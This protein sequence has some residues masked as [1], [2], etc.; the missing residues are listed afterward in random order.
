[1]STAPIPWWTATWERARERHPGLARCVQPVL[2]VWTEL[3]RIELVDRSLAL[4][5][6]ALLALIPLLMVL[7]VAAGHIGADGLAQVRDVMGVPEDELG[8]LVTQVERTTPDTTTL[9]VVVAL[10][11]ATSFS[12][13]LARMYAQVWQLERYRGLRAIRGSVVWLVGW[14]L[15]LQ[16]TA[17][18]I[19]WS[20]PVPISSLLIQLVGT[21]LIWWWT[22]HL[23]LGGRVSWWRLLPGGVATGALLVAFSQLSHL[24]MPAYTRA[25]LAQFDSLGIVFAIA[26]WLVAFGGV[27]TVAAVAGRLVADLVDR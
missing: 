2:A 1:M 12:R 6:Q 25:N 20:A 4:G 26:S 10:L 3:S 8:A 23:L 14:I 17:A 7:S 21:S 15:M 9:S 5:A 19:G 11:S 22:A 16:A 24:F 18:L 27:L 13:A